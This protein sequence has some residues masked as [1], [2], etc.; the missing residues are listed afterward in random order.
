MMP[1]PESLRTV[2]FDLDGTLVDTAP[3]LAAALNR[4]RAEE[5]LEALPLEHI[6][7]SVSHGSRAM[8]CHGFGIAPEHPD[9]ER[10][11]KRFLE[12]YAADL[13]SATR[14]FAGMEAVLD[15][16]EQL[17]LS[18][19]IVTN[20]PAYLTDPLIAALNL[21]S[22]A[23]C[24][25]SGDTTAQRKPHPAPVLYA[26][27]VVGSAPGNCLY[28]GDAQRD[29]EAGTRAGTGTVA[30]LFGYILP[31]DDPLSWG[32]DIAIESPGDLLACLPQVP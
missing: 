18:W 29:I 7:P 4:V 8:V 10:L 25:V 6:R 3:D 28:V 15:R 24:V 1:T 30:A 22:R 17:G 21:A 13:S 11:C 5:S 12:H 32:A 14:L 16:I 19:G 23:A 9:Y 20:K 26:C 27:E 31:T 2:L